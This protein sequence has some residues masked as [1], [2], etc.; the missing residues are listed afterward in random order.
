ML[1]YTEN[2]R[3][4]YQAL[5]IVGYFPRQNWCSVKGHLDSLWPIGLMSRVLPKVRETRLQSQVKSYQKLK[6]WYLMPLCGTIKEME[7]CPLL[8]FDVAAIEKGVIGS[9]STS[10]ANNFIYIYIYIY[11]HVV[12]SIGF[13][14]F[15]LEPFKIVVDS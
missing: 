10:V 2:S 14:T 11:I 9:P 8:H 15:F 5:K 3:P 7:K 12:N 13:Q 6:K 4:V 1:T